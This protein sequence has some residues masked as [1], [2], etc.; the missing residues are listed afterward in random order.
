MSIST[1]QL[2]LLL[3]YTPLLTTT[4]T[5]M[6]TL[7]EDLYLRPFTHLDPLAVNEIL[8]SYIARWFPAGFSVIL[9]LYPLTWITTMVNLLRMHGPQRRHA[10]RW[11]AA[12]LFFSIAH[13]WW[14]RR[15]KTLLDTIRRSPAQPQLPNGDPVTLLAAWLRL[16]VRRGLIADLP[17]GICFLIGALTRGRGVGHNHAA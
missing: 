7:C 5:L 3:H 2:Q 15:A 17:A 12:G 10:W 14:G 16:N 13:M 9:T 4:G 6:F 11:H 8:P 1:Q